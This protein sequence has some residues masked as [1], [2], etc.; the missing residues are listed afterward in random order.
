VRFTNHDCHADDLVSVGTLKFG[1]ELLL[2]PIAVKADLRIAIGSLFP[3]CTTALEEAQAHPSRHSGLGYDPQH[4]VAL[5][6]AK[7]V[8]SEPQGQPFS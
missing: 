2:N 1:G 5:T 7:G 3:I 8:H 4:H 6:T